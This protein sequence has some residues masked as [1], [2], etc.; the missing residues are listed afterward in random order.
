LDLYAD[1]CLQVGEMD[2]AK[3]LLLKSIEL[4][5]GSGASKYM[6][7]GQITE[8]V[9]AIK[10]YQRG[11]EILS[12]EKNQYI[13]NGNIDPDFIR[14]F[15]DNIISGLCSIAELYMTDECE[16]ENAEQECE[17]VLMEAFKIDEKNY[18]VLQLIGSFRIS[19]NK[20]DEAISYLLQ[21]KDNWYNDEDGG[22]PRE[23]KVNFVKLL[24]ELEQFQVSSQIIEDLIEENDADSE[25]WFLSAFSL[26]TIDP[27]EAR[28][29]LDK[30]C[31]ILNSSGN[32]IPPNI[33]EQIEDL[34]LKIN[35]V[36]QNTPKD[37][38]NF[39]EDNEEDNLDMENVEDMEI[40]S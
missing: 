32:D 20:K 13:L 28:Q 6:N 37:E 9:E 26:L 16:G 23:V 2:K 38:Q 39:D 30:C 4:V 15:N 35:T 7:L 34:N 18:E 3:E 10:C 5:P 11:T 21:S 27:S 36:L 12:E 25:L 14:N 1:L 29:S 19:Q 22:P 40:Y 8:G 24:L 33:V 31:E 17:K